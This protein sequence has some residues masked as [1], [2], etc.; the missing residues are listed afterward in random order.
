MKPICIT[1][2]RF[3]KMKKSGLAFIEGMPI[4]QTPPNPGLREP[5]NWKPYKLWYG[6]YWEC[7][8]CNAKII[9]GTGD[10]AI[11]EHFKEDFSKQWSLHDA[12]LQ[13]NDC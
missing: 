11:S 10:N 7:P 6:D 1:C 12:W 9:V 4:K 3:F 8:D 5:E 2:R 13:I